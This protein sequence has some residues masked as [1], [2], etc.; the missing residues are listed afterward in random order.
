MPCSPALQVNFVIC[1]DDSGQQFTLAEPVSPVPDH[2]LQWAGA[3]E[4]L[5]VA[6]RL[7]E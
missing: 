1:L 6:G 2:L 7:L 3:A 4:D 5:A